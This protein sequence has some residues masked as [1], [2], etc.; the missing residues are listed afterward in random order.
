MTKKQ[1]LILIGFIIILVSIPAT[2]YLVRQ[3]QIFAPKAAFIPKI[4]FVDATGNVITETTNPNVKLRIT[5]EAV[6]T[7][8]SPS[9]TQ[10]PSPSP[11]PQPGLDTSFDINVLVIKYFPVNAAG[12]IDLT[13]TGDVGESFAV[14]K[15]RTD[16]VTSQLKISLEKAS[17]YLGYKDLNAKPALRYTIIDTKE[18]L[19]AV[20]IKARA[21]KPTY[22]D[23]RGIMQTHN[24]CDYVDN[25]GVKEVWLWAYQGPPKADGHPY[26][27]IYES[28]MSGPFGDISSSGREDDMPICTN[29]YRVYTFNYTRFTAE[30]VESWG[31]QIE[32]E[33]GE[34]DSN[35]YRN[36]FQGAN[37]PQTL[38]VTGRCGSVH[39]PPNARFEYDR[40]NPTAQKSDCL[41]WNPDSL[42]QLTEISCQNWGCQDID[43]VSS[44]A[45]LNYQIWMLQN[46]PGRN[47]SKTYQ[48]KKL[49]NWWDI[50]GDFD[51]AMRTSKRLTL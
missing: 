11:S 31:H 3:T 43:P 48:S 4:E 51:N 25:K 24:I 47:N 26:L 35:L 15:K 33:M 42:G 5:K 22:P 19:Q 21:N 40:A 34:I 39:N 6:T 44:N 30:A 16:D 23:Y 14:I 45:A 46:M 20:P 18:Y 41:D 29:T 50:H 49:R 17:T 10:V 2:I 13:I 28:K 37:H 36:I 27:D 32:A 1:I 8:P 38:G 9:P 12:F 7:S